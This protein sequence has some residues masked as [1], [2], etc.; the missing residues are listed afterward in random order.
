MR[1]E[2]M[3]ELPLITIKIKIQNQIKKSPFITVFTPLEIIASCLPHQNP[4]ISRYHDSPPHRAKPC[5]E[6]GTHCVFLLSLLFL[7]GQ[8]LFPLVARVPP[9]LICCNIYLFYF[10]GIR[11]LPCYCCSASTSFLL[12]FLSSF[13]PHFLQLLPALGLQ[14]ATLLHPHSTS[15][16]KS[17]SS[18]SGT[19]EHQC[20]EH[21]G[22]LTN[23]LD[24][25]CKDTSSHTPHLS[26]LHIPARTPCTAQRLRE[27]WSPSPRSSAPRKPKKKKIEK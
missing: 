25:T 24:T 11:L 22:P 23:P 18:A 1:L 10:S 14:P 20:T 16:L 13:L 3:S 17:A 21:R 4:N 2:C 6:L 19:R 7:L 15:N 12:L 26:I 8:S 5:S 27:D 9:P